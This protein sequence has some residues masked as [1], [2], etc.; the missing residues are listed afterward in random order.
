MP[1][2]IALFFPGLFF[3]CM[4]IP[5]PSARAGSAVVTLTIWCFS[6]FLL[7][8][9]CMVGIRGNSSSAR[10]SLPVVAKGTFGEPYSM[11]SEE[12]RE[13]Y[14]QEYERYQQYPLKYTLGGTLAAHGW[15]GLTALCYL[16]FSLCH[17]A[18]DDGEGGRGPPLGAAGGGPA[19]GGGGGAVRGRGGGGE[20]G[21]VGAIGMK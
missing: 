14:R 18:V 20:D 2:K 12:G 5:S 16:L 4:D 15:T 6:Q 13:E 19:H 17:H 7:V 21:W 9:L 3:T 10:F 1:A 11:A 8:L